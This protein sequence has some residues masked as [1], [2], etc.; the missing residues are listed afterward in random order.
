MSSAGSVW[1][2]GFKLPYS[3]KLSREKTFA[4]FTVLWRFAKVFSAE[5]GGVAS[6]G[7]AE[8]SNPR[9]F[10]PGKLY[11]SP[12]CESFLPQKFFAIRYAVKFYC[13]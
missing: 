12:I 13:C 10:S 9:K 4:N 6:F 11:F 5:F 1:Y 2:V 8:T 3:G 7:A